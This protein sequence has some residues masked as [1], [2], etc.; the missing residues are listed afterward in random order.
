MNPSPDP[1]SPSRSDTEP[2][3]AHASSAYV[4][5][6]IEAGRRDADEGRTMSQVEAVAHVRA[7]IDATC[8]AKH[9]KARGAAG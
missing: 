4:R 3:W 8:R 2:D 7:R 9:S 1:P 5:M 6:S